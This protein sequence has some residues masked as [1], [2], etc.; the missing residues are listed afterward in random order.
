MIEIGNILEERYKIVKLASLYN[1]L[2]LIKK[3]TG[4]GMQNIIIL[5]ILTL[6]T[7]IDIKKK[8]IP[9]KL[10]IAGLAAWGILLA[11]GYVEITKSK[12]IEV[13]VITII[14]IAAYYLSKESIGFGDVKLLVLLALYLSL[15]DLIGVALVATISCGIFSGISL[16]LKKADKKTA[17]P[18]AP[19]LLLG[20]IVVLLL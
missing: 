1:L 12:A 20:S 6:A 15:S 8:L 9:N 10:V 17:I 3:R 18:F 13:V 14:L 2:E 5:G 7:G 11:V 19:F 4:D 16:L